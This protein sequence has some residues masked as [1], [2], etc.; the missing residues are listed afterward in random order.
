VAVHNVTW[1]ATSSGVGST[2]AI[3]DAINWLTGGLA[4]ISK[5]KVKSYHGARMTMLRAQIKQ[6][7]AAKQSIS[8]LGP[9]L[10]EKLSQS[11]D[12]EKRIDDEKVMHIRLSI[13]SLVVGSIELSDGSGEEIKGRIKLEVYPGQDSVENARDM[14]MVAAV[15]ANAEGLPTELDL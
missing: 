5:E 4:E 1:N 11:E 13:S 2:Q 15:K 9:E 6:K 8:H 7:K 12:L 3:E 14:L 10:L